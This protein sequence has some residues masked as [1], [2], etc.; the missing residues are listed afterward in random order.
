MKK[1][2]A[3]TIK[4][5]IVLTLISFICVGLLSICNVFLRYV[6]TLDADM[7][8]QLYKVCPTG[9]ATDE[10]ALEYFEILDNERQIKAVNKAN[11]STGGEV[12]AVYKAKKGTNE[13]RYIVQAQ[14]N[15]RDGAIIMLTAFDENNKIMKTIC[16]SQN[17][18]FWTKID[19][20]WFDKLIG[21]DSAITGNDIQASSGAT[22]SLNAIAKAITISGVMINEITGA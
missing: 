18:S 11:K 8:K 6:P 13:G 5:V 12:L 21:Q 22:L 15:G 20:S 1:T 16:Y 14:A 9:E 3:D 10:N 2:T 17:E 4:S 7:A 19:E